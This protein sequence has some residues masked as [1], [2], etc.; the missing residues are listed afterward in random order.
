MDKKLFIPIILGTN[1]DGRQSEWVAKWIVQELAGDD[2]IE[3]QLFDVRDFNLPEDN[4]GQGIKESFSEY[5]NA[6][7]RCDGMIIV[8]PEYNHSFPGRLKSVLDLLLAEYAHK[9]VGMVAVSAGPWGGVRMIES[10]IGVTRELGLTV[11]S[12]DL[13]FPQVRNTFNEDGTMKEGVVRGNK[14]RF[15]SFLSELLW[16]S[17][18]LRWGRENIPSEFREK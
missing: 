3:T 14:E 17:N 11:T 13:Q 4:Y 5:R 12:V 9:A 18:T 1:R 15:E 8:A 6:I 16:M 10:L 2:T 7:V